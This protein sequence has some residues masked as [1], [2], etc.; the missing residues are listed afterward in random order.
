MNKQKPAFEWQTIECDADWEQVC[1]AYPTHPTPTQEHSV[2][3]QRLWI[4]VALFLLLTGVSRWWWHTAQQEP[5]AGTGQEL[6]TLI[7]RKTSRPRSGQGDFTPPAEGLRMAIHTGKLAAQPDITLD[8][9]ELHGDRALAKVLIGAGAGESAQRQTRFYRRTATG[10]V[11][12]A[13]DAALWGTERSLE[14][15][16]FVFH[17]RQNDAQAVIAF[18]PQIDELNTT[19]RR[20]FGLPIMP[21][22]QK[23][24]IE[25]S[26]TEPPG[27]ATAL[28]RAPNRILVP[29]PAVYLAPVELTDAD[30][31]A[32][33]IALSM[34]EQMLAQAKLAQA[35][36]DHAIPSSWWPLLDGLRLWQMWDLNL[37]LA[38]WRTEV[39]QWL[40]LDVPTSRPE[41]PITLPDRYMELCA[42]HKLWLPT[43][44]EINIPFLCTELNGE[45]AHL[46]PQVWLDPPA[47]LDELTSRSSAELL[48]DPPAASHPGRTVAL[49]TLIE[50][51]VAT[52]GRD[53]LPILV[54]G[55]GQYDSWDT[56]LPAVY[57]VSPTEFEAGW[58]AYLT[59]HYRKS[60]RREP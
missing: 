41:E 15:P 29:S 46:L 25:V 5:T 54:A 6:R 20:N 31:L 60:S 26:V 24:E 44:M 37:P 40:Y 56:L 2:A 27:H 52:Y 33:S 58:Q 23:L 51:A 19:M 39:V 50:Y 21:T 57:G 49:A 45:D 16:H 36:E 59:T 47:H 34:V 11:Q 55:L 42:V 43:P 18:A 8:A 48:V 9:I 38:L 17:F 35:K 22:S 13:P 3:K 28:L 1:A 7:Q 10:W 30:L 14:T 12:T 53:R 32:Q 4:A